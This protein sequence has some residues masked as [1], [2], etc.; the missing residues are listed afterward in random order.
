MNNR[1]YTT[2][3]Q[4][5]FRPP[6]PRFFVWIFRYAILPM[7]VLFIVMHVLIAGLLYIG[8]TVPVRMSMFMLTHQVQGGNVQQIW[9]EYDDIAKSVK[10]AAIASEDANFVHHDGFDFD[11]IEQALKTNQA[12]GQTI[13]GGSTISQQLAKNLFLTQHRSYI[14]KSEEAIITVMMERMWDKKRILHVYL[15]VAE[16]GN[17]IYGIE[18]AA[19][20]Y[21]KKSAKSLSNDEAAKLISM[22]PRPKYYEQNF[23]H[24]RL[25]NKQRII[26]RRL[27]QAQ[28]P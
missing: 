14:K 6:K 1:A 19:W 9:V 10:A 13:Q 22:L 3:T 16:F 4:P 21:Y 5:K 8:K 28:L 17:G 23:N 26:V 20:H 2:P 11:A 18:A 15:N 27:K 12:K 7:L 25:K 24:K